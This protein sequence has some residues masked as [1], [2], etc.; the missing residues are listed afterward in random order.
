MYMAILMLEH[1]RT[2]NIDDSTDK[3]CCTSVVHIVEARSQRTQY[4][5]LTVEMLQV[6]FALMKMTSNVW[7][8]VRDPVADVK[9]DRKSYCSMMGTSIRVHVGAECTCT[10]I[11]I[12]QWSTRL[13]TAK[14]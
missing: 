5:V 3:S 6:Q 7:P 11:N 10:A 13:L 8:A 4:I 9:D 1:S 2:I 14:C 12:V